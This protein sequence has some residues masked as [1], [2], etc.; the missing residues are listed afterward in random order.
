MFEISGT[1]ILFK[2]ENSAENILENINFKI[3]SHSSIGLIGKNGC[4]KST[5]FKIVL[6]ELEI[7]RGNI[8]RGDYSI[9]YLPQDIS[10]GNDLT[11]EEYFF[12]L[13][14]E[15]EELKKYI[16]SYYDTISSI[17]DD[18]LSEYVALYSEKGGYEYEVAVENAFSR[19]GFNKEDIKRKIETFSGGEKTRLALSAVTLE[20]PDLLLLDEPTNHLDREGIE[21]LENYLKNIKIPFI[22]ISHDRKFLDN[23]INTIWEIKNKSLTLYSGNYSFYKNTKEEKFSHDM[24][25]YKTQQRKVKQLKKSLSDRKDWAKSHQTETGPNGYAPS[26]E[27]VTNFAKSSMKRAKNIEKRLEMMIEK[28][29]AEKPFIE[30]KR[31]ICFSD[32]GVLKNKIVLS[33]ESLSK[34][35]GFKDVLNNLSFEVENGSRTAVTGINGSGKSTLLKILTGEISDYEGN[36]KKAPSARVAYYA[37]EHET[38]NED[39][40]IIENVADTSKDKQERARTILGSL[41]IRRDM[42]YQKVSELSSGEKSKVAMAKI[43]LSGANLLILDEPTNH[44]EIDAREAIENALQEYNGT[45]LFVSHDRY[46]IEKLATDYI[47]L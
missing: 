39:K 22:V 14:S 29:E 36:I 25:M 46:F 28:E 33:S 23:C 31:K 2:Y 7:D 13:K 15:L 10:L 45:I 42:V 8:Y 19:A 21:E 34:S 40:S 16:D 12:S 37:Q 4:G 35:F 9:G 38:L 32:K 44:L 18:K 27:S 6:N 47:E 3:N 30:K 20:S 41:N 24:L 11:A 17:S 26:Y 5:L 1:E 43:I